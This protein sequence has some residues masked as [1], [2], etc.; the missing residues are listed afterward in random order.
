MSDHGPT[1]NSPVTPGPA[2][3]APGWI[4]LAN[5]H[6]RFE[7]NLAA[8]RQRDPTLA[9]SLGELSPVGDY[10]LTTAGESIQLG[11]RENSAAAI[12]ILPNPLPPRLARQFIQK[13]FPAALLTEP[14]LVAGL[15]QGWLWDGLH[16]LSTALPAAPTMRMPLYFLVADV[17]RLWAVLHYQDWS[18]LLADP[19]VQLAVGPAATAMLWDT[20]AGNTR[21]RIPRLSVIVEPALWRDGETFDTWRARLNGHLEA[22]FTQSRA[23]LALI[24][25]RPTS[26]VFSPGE[27]RGL[28]LPS[29][30]PLRILGITS[31]FTTFLQYSMRDWL[32][33]FG[34]LGHETRLLIEPTDHEMLTSL[35]FADTCRAFRPDLI[36]MIDHCRGEY[37]GLPENV[38]FVMWIQ[39]R[40][41]SIFRTEA[42][43][44]QKSLD[45]VIGYGFE[46]CTTR[47]GY[48]PNR[49][50]PA[51]VG[52]NDA[53]F[54]DDPVRPDEL[55][56]FRCDVSFVSH[57]SITAEQIVREE[58]DRAGAEPARRLLDDIL[59][60]LRA[61]YDAGGCITE[62]A[63]IRA[64][65]ESAMLDR[66]VRCDIG[67]LLD[68][69]IQRINNALLR[70]QSIR[71]VV[72][73]GVDLKLY[74]KGWEK[75]PE[76]SRFA[77]GVA[78]HQSQ[79]ASV[80]RA[81]AVNMQVTPF[82]SAH[83]RLF[84]GLAAGG[85]F[86]IRGVA[87]DAADMVLREIW[88]WCQSRRIDSAT[89]LFE[90]ADAEAM[91]LFDQVK[92][93]RGRHPAEDAT[94]FF[95]G[96]RE[97][98]AGEFTRSAGV[99]WPEFS[100][101][102]FWDRAQLQQKVKHFLAQPTERRQITTAM[103][104]RVVECHTYSAISRRMLSFIASRLAAQNAEATPVVLTRQQAA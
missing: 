38:P 84:E 50:M 78:D 57:A 83:Q 81:T 41:P 54:T 30:R 70:H 88:N 48:P 31:R 76:F 35:D 3:P 68:L 43:Q 104:R 25:P 96:L 67:P 95:A 77:C 99:L 7:S 60:R 26:P 29:D 17:E 22:R 65:V 18:S 93:L 21:L 72:E 75:H 101:V 56:R 98:A 73:L 14:A 5:F 92:S 33:A 24:Y 11:H 36:L 2:A 44:M 34:S 27:P 74:G 32:A 100:Q 63:H 80:Y 20:L 103:R 89:E 85:F 1:S 28:S 37:T 47:W 6:V 87:G 51:M 66:H 94:I 53:R 9:R 15:D 13:M 39:D 40:L 12:R 49:F 52:V 10:F 86:L 55:D 58:A 90:Q 71:W 61:I 82:G 42:G 64:L 8:L 97:A 69:V 45:F 23:E 91:R 79:L 62:P 102:A 16:K 59:G 4:P 46:E 19:R